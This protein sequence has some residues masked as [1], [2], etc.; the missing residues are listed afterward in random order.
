MAFGFS[1]RHFVILS[2]TR[3]CFYKNTTQY[4]TVIFMKKRQ[5]KQFYHDKSSFDLFAYITE[6]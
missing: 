3:D 6:D 2:L 5:N 4:K 1:E